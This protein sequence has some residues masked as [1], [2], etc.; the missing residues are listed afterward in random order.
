MSNW[1]DGRVPSAAYALS[2]LT[3]ELSESDPNCTFEFFDNPNL[4]FTLLAVISPIFCFFGVF[5]NLLT[6][7]VFTRRHLRTSSNWYLV[8]IAVSDIGELKYVLSIDSKVE[9][10]FVGVLISFI[11]LYSVEMIYDYFRMV[12]LYSLWFSYVHVFYWMSHAFQINAMYLTVFAT[13][14]RGIGLTF[15]RVAR[16]YCT[17]RGTAATAVFVLL[18]VVGLTGP[19]YWEM[20]TN[21][22]VRCAGFGR[23]N[24]TQ[25]ALLLNPTYVLVY[26]L[27]LGNIA[28]CFLPFTV[29]LVMNILILWK[30]THTFHCQELKERRGVLT[31]LNRRLRARAK[32]RKTK[33]ATTILLVVVFVFLGCNA[34]S[35]VMSILEKI[36]IEFLLQR[37]NFYDFARDFINLLA[38]VNSSANFLIYLVFGKEF[39]RLTGFILTR[40][41]TRHEFDIPT[42]TDERDSSI[43]KRIHNGS[44]AAG[45]AERMLRQED[46]GAADFYIFRRDQNSVW[47]SFIRCHM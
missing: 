10:Y 14:E 46:S 34:P 42:S 31:P 2:T 13:V 47:S 4:K 28:F 40:L 8:C 21:T 19:K 41:L 24:L 7:L 22:N 26:S 18:G 32:R 1:S 36:D 27:W 25:S 23:Y 39:R 43:V 16:V 45:S 6:I 3:P 30:I 9:W 35:V 15:P 20:E 44:V 37:R 38:V 5:G 11:L 29:L 12:E 33:E 17:N